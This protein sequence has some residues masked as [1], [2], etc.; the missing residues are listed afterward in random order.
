MGSHSRSDERD[1]KKHS[2]SSHRDDRDSKRHRSSRD[3]ASSKDKDR[4]KSSGSSSRS[5]RDRDR[6]RSSHSSSSK[7]RHDVSKGDEDDEDEWVEKAPSPGAQQQKEQQPRPPVDTVG[8]FEVGSM[9]TA[10][11]LRRLEGE[12]M[13]DGFGEGDVGGSSSRGGGLFGLPG[14][15]KEGQDEADFFGSF[16]TERRRKEPKEKVDPTQMMGQSSRELN[17]AYWQGAPNPAAASSAAAAPP[18]P[19]TGSPAP[20]SS[21]SAWRMT[22]LRRTYEAAEEEGRPIEEIAIERYG[23]LEAFEEAKEER[24]VLD[25]RGDR[26]KSRRESG[27][28]GGAA[29]DGARTPTG[30]A[31]DGGG[32]RFVFTEM[33]AAGDGSRPS[34]RQSFRRPGEAPPGIARSSSTSSVAGATSGSRGSTPIPSVLTPPVARRMPSALS[35][36]TLVNP[37]PTSTGP[38]VSSNSSAPLGST[39]PVLS[40]SDLNKLQARVLKAKLLESDDAADLEAEY[41]RELKRSMDAGPAVAEKEGMEQTLGGSRAQGQDVQVLPTVDG[42]GRMYDVGVGTALAD[43]HEEERKAKGRRGKKEMAFQSHDPQTGEVIRNNADDDSLSLQDLVRQ[44]RFSGG[45]DDARAL[46]A[47]FANRIATDARFTM[48]LDYIDENAEKLARAK[49]KSEAM[50]RQFAI[51]D[52]AR[53][54]KALDSCTLCYSDEGAPPKAPVVALGTQVYLALMENEE[55][56]PGHCR[57]VPVQH[58][59][60]CLEI[61]EEEGWDEIKNFMKTLMQ[62]FAAQDK[63]VVFFETIINH[64]QQRHSYIEAIPVSFDLFDQLPIYFQEAISTSESEWSQHKKLITF[65]PA[66]PFRRSLVPNLPYFAV[67]FDYKGEKGYG[68]VIEGVDDAPDRDLD[69]EERRGDLGDKGGGEFP[70]YFAQEIIGN[71]LSLEPRKWR[72]P[73]RLDRRDNPKRIADFRKMYDAYDWTKML[74]GGSGGPQ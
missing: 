36:S 65:T 58:Y 38:A 22:K 57:I 54:K 11:G 27:F 28:G 31:A 18:T 17:K 5:Y 13:T 72:K 62:M 33:D 69:G 24:R 40:Q 39:K 26:R 53:T 6:E 32:R 1:S 59:L 41:E 19:S 47:S 55:L 23:S 45:Q 35:Q 14:D 8:T 60:S 9:P 67:Q 46:D 44:E 12:D 3:E 34:S 68:H 2:R 37:D 70:R 49:M 52:Y 7:R 4:H 42:R 66:R 43:K 10:A 63:G 50:K 25:E 73:R 56:V 21:G 51:N 15:G 30:M 48:D 64:K 16:G 20:G 74:P 71:L 61:D 29:R